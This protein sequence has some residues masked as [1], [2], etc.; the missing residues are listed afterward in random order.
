MP[1]ALPASEPD[2]VP[3]FQYGQCARHFSLSLLYIPAKDVAEDSSQLFDHF[4]CDAPQH[5]QYAAPE[6]KVIEMADLFMLHKERN[7]TP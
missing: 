4:A 2:A 1:F 3:V 5:R 7:L 6:N